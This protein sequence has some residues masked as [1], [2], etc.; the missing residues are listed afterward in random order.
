MDMS[1]QIKNLFKKSMSNMKFLTL[2]STDLFSLEN[3]ALDFQR[4]LAQKKISLL[5]TLKTMRNAMS[6]TMMVCTIDI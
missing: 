5:S 6:Y 1:G 3:S 2:E 4:A